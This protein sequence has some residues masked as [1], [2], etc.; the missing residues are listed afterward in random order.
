MTLSNWS[1]EI[2]RGGPTSDSGSGVVRRLVRSYV[3]PGGVPEPG[4]GRDK[5]VLLL[6]CQTRWPKI[7]WVQV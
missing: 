6:G 1:S 5:E 3:A 4:L 7:N 2:V